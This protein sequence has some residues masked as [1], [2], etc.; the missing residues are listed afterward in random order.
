MKWSLVALASLAVLAIATIAALPRIVD[1]PRFQSLIA[2][3][4]TQALA[5]PVRFHSA[6]VSVLPVPAVRLRGVEIAEDPSFGTGPFVRLDDADFRLRLWPLVRGHVEFAT[7]V[8]KRPTITL[9]YGSGGRWNFASLGGSRE[10]PAAPRAPRAG[11][12][13]TPPALVGRVVI[14]KG[15]VVYE[16]RGAGHV[17]GHQRLE[18]VN[19]TLAPRVGALSFKGSARVVP[20]GLAV[21]VF[22]GT[23]GLGGARALAEASLRG[24]MEIE[25]A[26]VGPLAATALGD[27]AALGGALTGRL[28]LSGTVGRPRAAGEVEWR[29]AT[30]T[31]TSAACAEPRRRTLALATVK[32]RVSWR[33]GRLVAEPLTTGVSPGTVTARFTATTS[34]P[35]RAD[36]SDLVVERVPAERVLADFLC[37][38]YALAGPLDLTGT[39]ALSPD[40]PLRT[41]SGRGRFHVGA[42]KVVGGRA[43]TL[44]A[45]LT[46]VGVS[47]LPSPDPSAAAP[48]EFDSIDGSFEISNGVVTSRD[49]LYAS[50]AMTVRAKGDYAMPTGQVNADV[51]LEHRRGVLQAKVTG[52]GDSPSIRASTSLARQLDP[53]RAER[54]F[55]EL[56]K[57]FR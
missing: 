5:R 14:D 54:G 33:D 44:L 10:G 51:V 6:S 52:P 8:L 24:R 13:A 35:R 53:D 42:G 17:D 45:G 48:L 25:G 39:L 55:R 21:R 7:V 28:D 37:H 49:V 57:R 50:P 22:D 15:I 38:G 4:V 32:A 9:A 20:A 16:R 30:V 3:S 18:D 43:L 23:I 2:S 11:V 36:L 29:D 46:R 47:A 31:R 26:D 27:E 34:A 12:G 56:L 19:A 41:L 1:T 40:D